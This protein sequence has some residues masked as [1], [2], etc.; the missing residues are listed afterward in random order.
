MKISKIA[1]LFLI[2]FNLIISSCASYCSQESFSSP[3]I[4]FNENSFNSSS[5]SSESS[6]SLSSFTSSSEIN[7][8][9][10]ST[11]SNESSHS[12]S[13]QLHYD[14]KPIPDD[15]T[16]YYKS[17]FNDEIGEPDQGI[18]IAGLYR[19]YKEDKERLMRQLEYK[20]V[21]DM[22]LETSYRCYYLRQSAYDEFLAANIRGCEFNYWLNSA[23]SGLVSFFSGINMHRFS[24]ETMNQPI[25]ELIVDSKTESIPNKIDD[26]CLLDVVRYYRFNNTKIYGEYNPNYEPQIVIDFMTFESGDELAIINKKETKDRYR[27]FNSSFA[28]PEDFFNYNTQYYKFSFFAKLTWFIGRE[29]IVEENGVDV[30][31]AGLYYY[32][33][34]DP[35]FNDDLEECVIRKVFK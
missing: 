24:E 21:Y 33:N 2:I 15:L 13:E 8:S 28:K 14:L 17:N 20:C 5:I 35:S 23:Y 18:G 19:L 1:P 12:L 27:F 32:K 25:M 4:N 6:S 7:F 3:L 9:F 22:S 30:I 10:S 26:Y 31:N 11:K 34:V 29:E 16:S